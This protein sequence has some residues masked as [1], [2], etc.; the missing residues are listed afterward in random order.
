MLVSWHKLKGR[1]LTTA[2]CTK[3]K[4]RKR[5][6]LEEEEI[7][8]SL[9]RAFQEYGEPLETVTS[10]K[11]LGR[12]M[13]ADEGWPEVAGNLRKSLKSWTQMTR[14]LGREGAEPRISVFFKAA[15][16][17][18][19]ILGL[20]TWVLTPRMEQ[21]LGIFQH[22][23]AQQ[24]TGRQP[25]RRVCVWV[26][27]YTFLAAAMEEAG[28][29]EIGVYIKRF[30]VQSRNILRRDRFWTSVSNLFGD[31]ES[32]FLGGGGIRRGLN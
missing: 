19:L 30:R 21:D 17:A 18:V 22:R 12:V 26:R 13:M 15:V 7:R 6:R 4:E 14:I 28:F 27:D 32:R 24:I 5:R 20:E 2:Q 1:H 9:E 25:M 11:Y 8:V 16:Q 29:E 23:V 31:Q 3:G 10:F